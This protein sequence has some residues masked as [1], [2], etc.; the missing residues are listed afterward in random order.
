MA[1]TPSVSDEAILAAAK[2][3][4]RRKGI[5][6]FTLSAVATEVGLSRAAIILRFKS[7]EALKVILLEKAVTQFTDTL[8]ALPKIPGGDGL[9]AIADFLG[10]HTGSRAGSSAYFTDYTQ[11]VINRD[12]LRLEETRG[13]ALH[14]A[15]ASV[16]PELAIGKLNATLLFRSH[17]TGSILAWLSTEEEQA[18]EFLLSRTRDWLRL[19]GIPFS[20]SAANCD[21]AQ[22]DSRAST[23][24]KMN[25]TQSACE[26][27]DAD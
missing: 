26:V 17:L 12:L 20:D 22:A 8:Q 21:S 5:N 27:N 18:R 13:A 7:A 14:N 15:I 10:T 9:L 16:M 25:C 3:V 2:A 1:R 23:A 24:V 6:G 11:K 19:A 4:M